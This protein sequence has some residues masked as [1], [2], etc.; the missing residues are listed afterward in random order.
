MTWNRKC[1]YFRK[2]TVNKTIKTRKKTS[3][4]LKPPNPKKSP[5]LK[6]LKTKRNKSAKVFLKKLKASTAKIMMMPFADCLVGIRKSKL[7]IDFC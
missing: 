5:F 7:S 1:L 6:Y 2:A 3:T 4:K